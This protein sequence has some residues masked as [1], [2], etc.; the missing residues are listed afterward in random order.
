MTM[1]GERAWLI[2][3]DNALV[4]D[5][6]GDVNAVITDPPYGAEVHHKDRIGRSALGEIDA[7]KIPFSALTDVDRE[8]MGL[9]AMERVKGWS[10]IFCQDEGITAWRERM[11]TFYGHGTRF[12]RPMIWLKPNAKPNLQGDGPGK[13]H[14]MIQAYWS[15]PG[16]PQWNGGG[17]VGVFIHNRPHRPIHPTEKPVSLM[18]ELVRLFTN[19]GDVIFDPF[20]G[21]GSTGVAAIELGR[22]FIGVERNPDYFATAKQRIGEALSKNDLFTPIIGDRMPTLFGGPVFGSTGTK[23]RLRREAKERMDEN[24]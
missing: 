9:F 13:G 17:K 10:L 4:Y 7:V 20:M 8:L 15:G 5:M 18:K 22:K 6:L 19:P 11:D 23:R 16:R 3:D 24:T 21:S 2:N 1:M 12:Y 14:E